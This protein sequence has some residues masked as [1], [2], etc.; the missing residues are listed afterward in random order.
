MN[1]RRLEPHARV[2]LHNGDRLVLAGTWY[3][4]VDTEPPP[5]QEDTSAEVRGGT[6]AGSHGVAPSLTVNASSRPS[7]D[8]STLTRSWLRV[9]VRVLGCGRRAVGRGL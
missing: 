3:L 7:C 8:G 9:S 6:A 1:G 5:S 4:R 2:E